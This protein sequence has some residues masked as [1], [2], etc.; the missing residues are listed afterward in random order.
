MTDDKAAELVAVVAVGEVP[1]GGLERVDQALE[2]GADEYV[3]KP[4]DGEI[5]ASK[6]TLAGVA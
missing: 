6:I 5:L 3:M 4:F 1:A 2:A